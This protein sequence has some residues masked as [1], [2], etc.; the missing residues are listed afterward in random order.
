MTTDSSTPSTTGRVAAV[1]LAFTD[2]DTPLGVSEI[3]RACHLSKAVVH[4][5]LQS[6]VESGLVR[7]LTPER[8][9]ALG[10]AALALGRHAERLDDLREA[11]LPGIS[12]LADVTGETTTLTARIGHSRR[13]IAQVESTHRIRIAI[14]VGESVPLST[15][16]SGLS[17]LAFLPDADVDLILSRPLTAYTERSSTD[18]DTIRARLAE[19]REQGWA[20]SAGERVRYSSSVAAPIVN[21][22]GEPAGS[23]SVA[24]LADR[25]PDH[26]PLTDLVVAT[27]AE[28]SARLQRREL[29]EADHS[30]DAG[31]RMPGRA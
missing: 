23:L 31:A 24:Y 10:P 1:L 5:I 16:A 11:G 21:S 8:R 12:H 26:R 25:L 19:I 4:R 30:S 7:Y 13:Y 15:G 3:A 14:R 27:A 28:V 22:L 17:I 29:G 2:A 20:H 6:L 9:Y 18:P